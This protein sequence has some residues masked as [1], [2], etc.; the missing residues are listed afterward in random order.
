MVS[1]VNGR[2][3]ITLSDLLWQLALQPGVPLEV[4]RT[5]DLRR[6][7][8]LLIDQRLIAIEAEKL[9]AVAPTEEEIN[10]ELALLVKRFPSQSDF[11][12]RLERVG[13]GRDSAQLREIVRERV[14]ISKYLDFRFRSFTVVTPQEVEEYYRDSFVQRFR[15]ESPGRIVPTLEEVF[16]RTQ[17]E[18][19]EAKIEA[20]TDAFL[21]EMRE[22]AEI[23]VLDPRFENGR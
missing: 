13:L 22:T 21:Q 18:L 19:I 3:L 5:E 1:V 20:D 6:A 16:E 12:A 15:R 10:Q 14:R 8:D 2:E 9:P 23:T 11:Y 7:L 4:P 17:A